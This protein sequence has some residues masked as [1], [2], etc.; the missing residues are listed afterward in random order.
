MSERYEGRD[1]GSGLVSVEK[2]GG[3]AV[4]EV[5]SDGGVEFG[6]G[7]FSVERRALRIEVEAT[8]TGRG[9]SMV[10]A[11]IL[12]SVRLHKG[13]EQQHAD[14]ELY[15]TYEVVSHLPDFAASLAPSLNLYP[16]SFNSPAEGVEASWTSRIALP[17]LVTFSTE[18]SSSIAARV[19]K[20]PLC[21][22]K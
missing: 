19:A 10:A 20:P 6:A 11:V 12:C 22:D 21:V 13:I 5:V 9:E 17:L 8:L 7:S 18:F 14:S 16:L 3:K 4:E 1:E 2:E 15:R